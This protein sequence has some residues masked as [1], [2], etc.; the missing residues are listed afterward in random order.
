MEKQISEKCVSCTHLFCLFEL[1]RRRSINTEEMLSDTPY[2]LAHLTDASCFISWECFTQLLL[3]IARCTDD[4]D[5][6]D[7]GGR[8]WRYHLRLTHSHMTPGIREHYL[9]HFGVTGSCSQHFPVVSTT[10]QSS[11]T[12]LVITLNMQEGYLAC[13]PFFILLA[14]QIEAL[15]TL[16]SW[17]PATVAIKLGSRRATY[18]VDLPGERLSVLRR[19][20]P[21]LSLIQPSR[22]RLAS[23]WSP[24]PMSASEKEALLTESLEQALL[25]QQ[26]TLEVLRESQQKLAHLDDRYRVIGEN[27]SDIIWLLDEQCRIHYV[28][29]SAH[30]VFGEVP[31][32]ADGY[33][34]EHYTEENQ[35]TGNDTKYRHPFTR[36][37]HT[38]GRS[39]RDYLPAS[40][41]P[42]FDAMWRNLMT[43]RT[44]RAHL[45]TEMLALDGSLIWFDLKLNHQADFKSVLCV[46]T[47]ISPQK[48]IEQELSD[49]IATHHAIANATLDTIVTMDAN[50]RIIYANPAAMQLFGYHPQELLGLDI[51]IIMPLLK[52]EPHL[53]NIHAVDSVAAASVKGIGLRKN[54]TAVFLEAT[55]NSHQVNGASCKTCVIHETAGVE[56]QE[57]GHR[58]LKA[59]ERQLH[60]A[61]KLNTLGQLSGEIAHD[62][63]NILA[64]ICGYADLALESKDR[65][66]L[67]SHLEEIIKAGQAGINMTR[68][69]LSF[70]RD[71]ATEPLL[72]D[73]SKLILDTRAIITHL[74]PAN[75]VTNFKLPATSA[76]LM[77]DPTQLKQVLINLAVNARDA[78]LSGGELTIELTDRPTQSLPQKP[79]PAQPAD[80]EGHSNTGQAQHQQGYMLTVTDTGIGIDHAIQKKI[81]DPFY[82]TKPGDKGTGLG[83]AVVAG[84]VEQHKGFINVSSSPGEHT[85]FSIFW[86]KGKLLQKP[87]RESHWTATEHKPPGIGGAETILLVEDDHQVRE[88]AQRILTDAGYKVIQANNGKRAVEQFKRFSETV[89]LVLMDIVMPQTGGREAAAQLRA[90]KPDVN[91]AFMSG[92]SANSIH[93]RFIKDQHPGVIHKPFG[94]GEF[95]ARVRALLDGDNQASN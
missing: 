68:K 10:R 38:T 26:G 66:E 24:R 63:N 75:I 2:S 40:A 21:W 57:A 73:F 51:D 37:T 16:L 6:R 13:I 7:T 30:P 5:L 22:H 17:K 9:T 34:V 49:H 56:Q 87:A 91:I 55:F 86:P 53:S 3:N 71:E 77:A 90:Y 4:A 31:C 36:N 88:L 76:W 93:T 83:L 60:A 82:T 89:D 1:C 64:A 92:Y 8:A 80:L 46:A 72:M 32:L 59:L 27:A 78:M 69:L 94:S 41:L 67:S 44:R 47:N 70:S 54:H 84:I 52:E 18:L 95:R 12:Q 23:P 65:N 45:E 79:N 33:V 48:L 62:F 25:I 28:S 20:M 19:M 43:D 58:S 15:P 35:A 14:G 29:P 85:Q 61:L 50:N 81:F 74:L 42:T 11:P 39:L